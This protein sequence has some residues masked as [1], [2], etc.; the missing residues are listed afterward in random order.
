MKTLLWSVPI[1]TGA[2]L[3][4][5]I[6]I[7]YQSKSTKPRDDPD[8]ESN[9][10]ENIDEINESNF[11]NVYEL[12]LTGFS[13]S[14]TL[15]CMLWRQSINDTIPQI[16]T[17]LHV[18]NEI[19]YISS[20]LIFYGLTQNNI[21]AIYS[22]NKPEYLI[23]QLA[24]T[25]QSMIASTLYDSFGSDAITYIVKLAEFDAIFVDN[26]KR[27]RR[28]VNV[29]KENKFKIKLIISLINIPKDVLDECENN[30][31]KI[32]TYQ[33]LEMI[34]RNNP[35]P[36]NVSFSFMIRSICRIGGPS[37]K[38]DVYTI[39][40]TS[41]TSGNP[42]GVELMHKNFISTVLSLSAFTEK[43]SN[44]FSFGIDDILLSYLPAAHIYEG[45]AE[46]VMVY[47]GG[48]IAYYGGN[49]KEIVNDSQFFKPSIYPTVPRIMNRVY[50]MTM[51]A[52]SQSFIKRTIFNIAY[53]WKRTTL[54]N[55]VYNSPLLD[56]FVF[57]KIISEKLGG[58][59][60][61]ITT[62]SAPISPKVLEFWRIVSG[63][64]HM[65]TDNYHYNVNNDV[66]QGYGLTETCS[67]SNLQMTR[68]IE[69]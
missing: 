47:K 6:Y 46:L 19:D 50:D 21:C 36:H 67:S 27:L 41:G 16:K 10:C 65:I 3:S 56:K 68:S 15:T 54:N 48:K 24:L 40:F 62:G 1:A 52:L 66:I 4:S 22:S 53:Y 63:A 49:I 42:K 43:K 25:V 18:K 51:A 45:T 55:G 64:C 61:L 37:K 7:N 8:S 59:L 14:E 31:F 11:Q 9:I 12:F 5:I 58:N 26:E 33:E 2:I 28:I 30:N 29:L 60:R 32:V 57:S 69:L 23:L 38:H 17:Y 13:F 35:V 20:G 34:G 44:P 39:Y